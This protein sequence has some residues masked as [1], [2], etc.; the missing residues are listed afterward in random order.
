[1]SFTENTK[2]GVIFM[3]SSNISTPHGFS[4]RFGGVSGGIYSS[5]NLGE[6]RGDS[7][8]NVRENYRRFCAVVGADQGRLVFSKQVHKTNVRDVTSADIHTLFETVPYEA[9]GLITAER[10]LS[11]VIFSA[12]CI[13]VLLHDPVKNVIG[14]CHCG[15][16]GTVADMAGSTV[17]TMLKKHGCDPKDIRAA[18]GPGIDKCC[19]V[20]DDDVPTAVR[21]A[22][23]DGAEKFIEPSDAGKYHVNLK[24]INREFLIRAGILPENIDVS[25]ECTA[26]KCDKYWSHRV[27]HGERGSQAAIIYLN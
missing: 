11:L 21:A 8:E 14:A 9:D 26:C 4:T 23:G 10:G 25:D 15:W 6:H 18:I 17:R 27:T 16:R 2:D 7:D 22:L 5:L 3:T 24:G 12:D 1:M 19:F 20:T 13:P